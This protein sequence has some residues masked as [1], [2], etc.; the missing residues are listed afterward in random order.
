VTKDLKEGDCLHIVNDR[1]TCL[2]T[3]KIMAWETSG[4]VFEEK[5]AMPKVIQR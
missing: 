5:E 4:F 3:G 2:F 1:K